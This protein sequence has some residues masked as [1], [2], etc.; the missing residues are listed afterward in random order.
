VFDTL[1]LELT[2]NGP[3]NV[4]EYGSVKTVEGFRSLLAM[5]SYR[6]IKDGV[7]YPAFMAVTSLNDANVDPSQTAKMIARLKAA[8]TSG[9]A[10]LWRLDEEGGHGVAATKP[11]EQTRFTDELAFLF[12]QLGVREFQIPKD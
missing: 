8:T 6:H 1:R 9:K 7:R 10:V 3:P 5:S 2:P 11:Q 12:W 4:H